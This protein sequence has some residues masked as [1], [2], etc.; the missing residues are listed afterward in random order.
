MKRDNGR[1]VAIGKGAT[2]KVNVNLGTSSDTIHPGEEIE[3]AHIA[4]KYGA[5]TITDLSMG[6]DIS[7][8]RKSIFENTSLLITTVPI[9]QAVVEKGLMDMNADDILSYLKAHVDEGVSS[10]VLHC[11]QKTMLDRIKGTGRVMG[12][13]SKGGSFTSVFM[14]SEKCENPFI[15]HFDEIMGILR[16]KMLCSLWVTPCVVAVSMICGTKPIKWR[17]RAMRSLPMRPMSTECR[18]L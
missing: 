9:Y 13:V 3:K 15:E 10:V 14:L 2:T 11:V 5:D 17:L 7:A 6:G 12:M 18:S 8:I 16:K 4:E 1:C